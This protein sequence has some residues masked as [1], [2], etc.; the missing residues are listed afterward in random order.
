MYR[1]LAS[2]WTPPR[3]VAESFP[4]I[5]AGLVILIAIACIVMIVAI[6]ASPPQTGRGSN[7]I[8]GASESY[9]TKNRGGNNQGRIRNL[10]II[11][12]AIIAVSAVLYFVSYGIYQGPIG[13]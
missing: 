11:C 10:V 6:L 5:Q 4:Y 8:T 12:A 1:L 2:S 9:Y 13:V 7:A 3:W